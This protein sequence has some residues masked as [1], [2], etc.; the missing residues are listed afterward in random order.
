MQ[1]YVASSC[2]YVRTYVGAN[3]QVDV[4]HFRSFDTAYEVYVKAVTYIHTCW[5]LPF[6]A[7]IRVEFLPRFLLH[8][9]V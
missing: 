4:S 9:I 7:R 8:R 3:K 1:S 2:A 5:V 6:F